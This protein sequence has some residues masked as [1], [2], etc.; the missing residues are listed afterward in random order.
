MS[1]FDVDAET[2]ERNRVEREARSQGWK[3]EDQFQGKP[4]TWID[5][6]EFVRKGV[7]IRTFT[8]REVERLNAALAQK[9]NELKEVRSTIEEVKKYHSEMEERAIQSAID[10]I[11]RDRKQALTDGNM[12][13]ADDL[14]EQIEELEKA[15]RL[16][17]KPTNKETQQESQPGTPPQMSAE[18][19]ALSN[20]WAARNQWTQST[21]P[22]YEDVQAFATGKAQRLSQRKDLTL[23]Q[24]FEILDSALATQFPSLFGEPEEQEQQPARRKAAASTSGAGEGGGSRRQQQSKRGTSSLPADARAAGERFVKQGLYKSIDDYAAEYW[25]QSGAS[26]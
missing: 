14:E 15:P 7:E 21:D 1:D 16:A 17:P 3:P 5:A 25:K 24:K 4:G 18:D 6:D 8:K 10:R 22:E 11:K 26:A 23:A 2:R 13:L 9:D 20:E 19:Q 12:A